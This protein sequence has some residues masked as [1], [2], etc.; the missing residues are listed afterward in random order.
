MEKKK[1]KLKTRILISIVLGILALIIGFC[2]FWANPSGD[3][4]EKIKE[5]EQA[6][7]KLCMYIGKADLS[8]TPTE[9]LLKMLQSQ[10]E[11]GD[12]EYGETNVPAWRGGVILAFSWKDLEEITDS[13]TYQNERTAKA[14]ALIRCKT[15]PIPE[16]SFEDYL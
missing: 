5:V 8:K 3:T 2:S 15:N 4:P 9:E 14:K 16:Y 1:I 6:I 10:K 7:E 11:G 13:L 12:V